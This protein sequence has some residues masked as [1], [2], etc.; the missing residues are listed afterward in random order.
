MFG[1]PGSR[2]QRKR[3]YASLNLLDSIS[4][5]FNGSATTFNLRLNGVAVI[6]VSASYLE[7]VLGGVQQQPLSAY[8]ISG[9]TITFSSA[10]ASTDS[11]FIIWMQTTGVLA[12]TPTVVP[13][14]SNT[15]IQYNSSGSFGG[16]ANLTWT[17]DSGLLTIG[18]STINVLANSTSVSV[19]N[20]TVNVS[21]NT[22]SLVIGNSTVNSIVNTTIF[23]VGN[24][25]VN[26]TINS[27]SFS[28]TGSQTAGGY[29]LPNGMILNY[30]LVVTNSTGVNVVTFS[31]AF[32]V[33][34][35]SVM[36]N[37]LGTSA[38]IHAH[39]NAVT[40]TGCSVYSTNTTAVTNT[41]VPGVYYMAIGY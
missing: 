10:P 22:T 37:P 13:G 11:C 24:S 2:Q 28:N 4:S 8:T 31:T 14:G 5:S 25:T 36:V 39:V 18:N 32:T 33:N 19:G 30:G 12:A 17:T 20:S 21:L 15:Y 1:S 3:A 6:P 35:Y 38:I 23:R 41:A 7:V 34:A 27:T 16:D 26:A 40:K 9:S 29:I